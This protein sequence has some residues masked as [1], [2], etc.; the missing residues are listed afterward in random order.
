MRKTQCKIGQLFH[1]L[2]LFPRVFTLFFFLFFFRPLLS[3]ESPRYPSL[4]SPGKGLRDAT[5][6]HRAGIADTINRPGL[7]RGLLVTA[8]YAVD[9]DGE[10]KK[11]KKKTGE[12]KR[13][14][15]RKSQLPLPPLIRLATR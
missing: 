13:T 4:K 5:I 1:H 7:R 8:R 6:G 11:K 12:A 15:A 10:E 9:R 2:S 14:E 3:P